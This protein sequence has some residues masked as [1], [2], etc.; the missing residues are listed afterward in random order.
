MKKNEN[1]FASAVRRG[2]TLVELLV[3]VAIIGILGAV[4]MTNF[5]GGTDDARESA[6]RMAVNNIDQAITMY[7][8]KHAKLPTNLQ[9]LIETKSDDEEPMLKGGDGAL[10]DPWGAEYKYET[11]GKK[12]VVI[13]AG[14]D[15]QFNTEDDIRSDTIKRKSK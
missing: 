3:V 2:F 8:V 5:I 4:A 11:K 9:A 10:E 12:F 6:A 14:P 15:G 13:S 7:K 1:K